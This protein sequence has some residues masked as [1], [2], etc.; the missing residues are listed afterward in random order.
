[1]NSFIL[2]FIVWYLDAG[3]P[4]QRRFAGHTAEV[5]NVAWHPHGEWLASTAFD[6]TLRVWEASSGRAG[7]IATCLSDFGLDLKFNA[8]GSRLFF[9]DSFRHELVRYQV[10]EPTVVQHTALPRLPPD[11]EMQR[12]PWGL[13]VSPDGRFAVVGGSLGTWVL[14]AS[15]G[16]LL[17]TLDSGLVN[18]VKFSADGRAFW[19]VVAWRGVLQCRLTEFGDG[20]WSILPRMVWPTKVGLARLSESPATGAMAVSTTDGLMLF[21]NIS[22]E[23]TPTK[24]ATGGV[25][26]NP[27]AMSPDGRWVVSGSYG[28]SRENVFVW[29]LQDTKPPG[30][31]PDTQ[32][33]YMVWSPDSRILYTVS[34][35]G[36]AALEAGTWRTLWSH[37]RADGLLTH[38]F[39]EISGDGTL[40]A[41]A[42]RDHGVELYTS[43][44]GQLL[45]TID[46]P[47]ARSIG[48]IAL[49]H[50]GARLA[51]NGNGCNIQLW[52]LRKLRGEL[53]TLGLDW[54]AAPFAPV[55][56]EAAVSVKDITVLPA[57]KWIGVDEFFKRL[58]KE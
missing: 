37:P 43:A 21:P 11:K 13:D 34:V 45:A 8:D 26:V 42:R 14:D 36:L 35:A 5:Q 22:Q 33:C 56:P 6:G 3:T 28:T 41:I 9:I 12:G 49:D 53:H 4:Y 16:R 7:L 57:L 20:R 27:V 29:D 24:L 51:I 48:W 38:S 1:V 15:D 23:Q 46:H 54:P 44:T 18:D 58:R 30:R 39:P 25:S 2:D 32:N 47:D 52:D 19:L 50:S 17:A 10:S 31:L 55:A 40:L